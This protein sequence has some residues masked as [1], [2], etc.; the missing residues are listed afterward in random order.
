MRLFRPVLASVLPIAVL[1]A[2]CVSRTDDVAYNPT[3]FGAPDAPP[4]VISPTEQPLGPGDVVTVRVFGVDSLS[5][6]QTVDQTGQINMPLIGGVPAAG[7]T[8]TQLGQELATRLG[9]RY[10]SSPQVNVTP[11]SFVAKTITVEGAVATPG[12]Y[13]VTGKTSLIQTIAMARGTTED[14]N[15]KQVI[16]FR[17]IAGERQAAAFDLTTIRKGTDPDPA[18]YAND[19]VVV[20]DSK[21]QRNFRNVLQTLPVI[22]L[23][24]R[25]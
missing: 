19:T 14:A 22:G 20:I 9:E 16:V 7:K 24:T 13:P 11:K 3:S 23:F 25:L 21:N 1:L 6:D 8:T 5:G 2:G 18:I 12:I 17:Q 4:T 10:L 15:L